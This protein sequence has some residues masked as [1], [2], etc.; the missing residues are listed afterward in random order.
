MRAPIHLLV[1]FS[2]LALLGSAAPQ[3]D[4]RA[5][6]PVERPA[7][8]EATLALFEYDRE[9]PL[10]IEENGVQQF[11]DYVRV[12]LSYA[13]PAGGR[14]PAL[15]FE[16]MSDGPHAGLL[17][18]HGMPGSRESNDDLG[19][20]YVGTGAIVLAISA[21]WARPDGPRDDI[22]RFD[23][24]DRAEQ[25]QLIQDLRRGVDL[26]LEMGADPERLGYAGG[27]YGGA[28]GGLLAGVEHRV[29]AYAL[30][31][32]DGGLLAHFTS[33]GDPVPPENVSE[34]RWKAWVAMME[35]I[36]PIRFVA[37]AAPSALLFQNGRT[38]QLVPAADAEQYQ[39]A[40]SEP[41]TIHWYETGHGLTPA[42]LRDQVN[43]LAE[44][45][46]IDAKGFPGL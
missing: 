5:P 11:E 12:D 36:E 34:E 14:V 21:P 20:R 19:R 35:P 43:W 25:I 9:A 41:K 44:H 24:R 22:L 3:D 39:R 2:A 32:G 45:I 38:D 8:D 4:A 30:A 40:G 29:R 31:V 15:Y 27:S 26:L 6:A 1:F 13:S 10:A 46:G 23:E 7:P 28:M 16:P 42:M 18:L 37:H 17:L 33:P